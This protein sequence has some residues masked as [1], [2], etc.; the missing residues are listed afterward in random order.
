[1]NLYRFEKI[2]FDS[3]YRINYPSFGGIGRNSKKL[4]EI[5]DGDVLFDLGF[6]PTESMLLSSEQGVLRGMH[7]QSENCR[8]QNKLLY[9]LTGNIELA[10]VDLRGDEETYG[11]WEKINISEEDNTCIYIP[12]EFAIG[13]LA[14]TNVLMQILYDGSHE[15]G[16]DR[17]FRFDDKEIGI[18][19]GM[20]ADRIIVSEKDLKLPLFKQRES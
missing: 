17:G 16:S 8:R 1:M 5:K 10:I 7:Y 19:W 3:V 9:V 4:F 14:E 11:K 2:G 20:D 12:K 13:T 15:E 6:I 18:E